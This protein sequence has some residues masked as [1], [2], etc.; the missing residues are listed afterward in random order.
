MLLLSCPV[1]V[2]ASK[3][4][5]NQEEKRFCVA[6]GLQGGWAAVNLSLLVVCPAWLVAG[7]NSG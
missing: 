2:G 7:R 3:K 5:Q 1:C 6:G 4:S